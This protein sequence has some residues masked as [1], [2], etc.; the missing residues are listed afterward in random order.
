MGTWYE[1]KRFPVFYEYGMKCVKADY[2]SINSTMITVKNS[3]VKSSGAANSV[4]GTA[5]I[6]DS[7]APNK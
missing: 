1:I 7:R 5:Y 6:P 2:G 3:G 4:E